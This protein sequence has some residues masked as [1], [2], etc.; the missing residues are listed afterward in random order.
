M[1]RLSCLTVFLGLWILYFSARAGYAA[2]WVRES[3]REI[4]VALEAD[5]AVVGGGT[6]AVSA[7]ARA[8]NVGSRVLLITSKPYLGEDLCSFFRLWL[9][10]GESPEGPLERS[11]FAHPDLEPVLPY[12]YQAN[13]PSSGKHLD[14]EPPSV[15][16]DGRWG[17]AYTQSVQYDDHVTLSLDLGEKHMLREFRIYFFQSN[18]N[19]EVSAVSLSGSEDGADWKE[20]LSLENERLGEGTYVDE[21]LCMKGALDG[22]AR[23]IR[24]TVKKGTQAQRMLLGEIQILGGAKEAAKSGTVAVV[25]PLHVK[26]ILDET[27][28]DAGVFFLYSSYADELLWDEEGRLAGLLI[29]NRAGRQAVLVR[30]VVDATHRAW[31]ARRSGAA[32]GDYP[33]G[34][35]AFKRVVVGGSP[36]QGLHVKSRQIPLSE[37]IGG[38]NT[39]RYGTGGF[40]ETVK[41]INQPMTRSISSL[42]KYQLFFSLKDASFSS[43]AEAEQRARDLTFHPDQMDASE[44]LFEIPPDRMKGEAR[45][46]REWPGAASAPLDAF[47]PK[48]VDGL[49]VLGPCADLSPQAAHCLVRPLEAIRMG[50]RIGLAAAQ[51]TVPLPVSKDTSLRIRGD[52]AS[53]LCVPG[54]TREALYGLRRRGPPCK[55]VRLRERNLPVLDSVDVVVAGG[56]TSGAPAAIGAARQGANT[57]VLEHLY[58]LGGVGT[59]G[60]IGVY[61]AGYRKG[62]TEEVDAGVAAL[63]CG[64][65][66]VGKQEWWRREILKA[67]GRIWFGVLVCGAFVEDS[68][69]KGVVV[70]TPEGRGVVLADVV[71]D[72]TGNGDVALA[73]GAQCMYVGSE[74]AAMQGTGL[75]RRE[76]GASYINT[77]WTYVDE[78]D[79][80]DVRSAFIQAKQR[81]K[82]A[83]D[84]AQLVDTRERRRVVGEMILSPL[85]IVNQRRFP[86]TVAISQG[87]RLDSHGFTIHP[88]YLI[89]NWHGGQTYTP[90]RCLLPRGWKGILV[91]G[92]AVSAHRDAIPSIRMQPCMQNLGYAAGVAAAMSSQTGKGPHEIDL[93]PLQSHLVEKGCLTPDVPEHEDSFPLPDDA[94]EDAVVC[95]TT[96]G[97]EKLGILLAAQDR[98]KPL[99][100][101]AYARCEERQGRLRLAHVL[102]VLGDDT[103]ILSLLEAVSGA[104]EFDEERIDRYFPC[105]TWLDSYIIALGRTKHR[106]ALAPL[107]EKLSLLHPKSSF[108]HFR[109]LAEALEQMGSREAAEP[110]AD[111]LDA[112]GKDQYVVTEEEA[113]EG[114]FRGKSGVR[115][116]I[117]ARVLYRCGD[118]ERRGKSVLEAYA[119]DVRGVFS[120][121]AD[122]V[123]SRVAGKNT[124]PER[125]LGE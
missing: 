108:S 111:L 1:R 106:D 21:A 42:T 69:V 89:N 24:C 36:V 31:L 49:F 59:T 5:V 94:V 79:M 82:G 57:L 23:Y 30:S 11:L 41:R 125:W 99:M 78:T 7:A 114:V 54:D 25:P 29:V 96:R 50:A 10:D 45:L 115:N 52:I 71:V 17:T 110:L 65:H 70:A 28:L 104:E 15:L 6:C 32:F 105:I 77:D 63:G 16:R 112:C 124:R 116:L 55:R 97:Y 73:A 95:L 121:H 44:A 86:D 109:A 88:F 83:W 93:D 74:H 4:P 58:A 12:E 107:L 43:F 14:T 37:P 67:G 18:N 72:A 102:G 60:M 84:L 27:L 51:R 117:L 119:R 68:I 8:A 53:S 75:P 123:L 80:V 35:R 66:I 46:D 9:E 92:L 120:R 101:E 91:V 122:A 2:E 34:L 33:S 81:N 19:Y 56:G 38:Q 76:L 103:G 87:G 13:M 47:Q 3:A 26:R 20:F 90:Y 39:L 98:S 64:T 113:L 62:F 100:R 118:H 61:C 48:G 85:D 40:S 22:K